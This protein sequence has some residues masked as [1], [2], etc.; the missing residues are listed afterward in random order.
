MINEVSIVMGSV[1]DWDAMSL[2]CETLGEYGI[3]Y[4]IN[5][6]SAHRNPIATHKYAI[7][8]DT[9][10]VKIIIAGAGGAAHLPGVIAASTVIP[11]IGVPIRTSL[12]GG[13][14]SMLSIVQMPKGVTVATVGINNSTNAALLAIQIL[15]LNDKELKNKIIVE[16]DKKEKES[17][18]FTHKE[19]ADAL[20]KRY[21]IQPLDML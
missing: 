3:Q 6:L 12:A 13:L 8:A 10:G 17:E 20:E 15:A 16:R 9:K 1:S 5:V 11:V 19:F 18:M 4:D 14:D 2:G 7:D 21:S